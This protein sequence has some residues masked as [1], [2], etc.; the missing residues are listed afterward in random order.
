MRKIFLT[1]I[2][3]TFPFAHIVFAQ[4]L[5]TI[6]A[7]SLNKVKNSKYSVFVEEKL[8][9]WKK[10]GEFEKTVDWQK[11]VQDSTAI[12]KV[13]IQES[14]IDEY[15]KA[16][17]VLE[18]YY[19]SSYELNDWFYDS[20]GQYDADKEVLVVNTFWGN[21]PIPIPL[22]E[23]KNMQED[24]RD[25]H[26][27][28]ARFFIQNDQLAL[29]SLIFSNNS[30]TYTYENPSQLAQIARNQR[31]EL[32]QKKAKELAEKERIEKEKES[33]QVFTHAEQMPQFPGGETEMMS[34]LSQ[35]IKY[36]EE[37]QKQGIQGAV[38][39]RFIIGKN[40][41]VSDVTVLRS[42]DPSCDKEA[43]RVVKSMKWIPG[44]QNGNPVNVYY[45]MPVRF[46][47]Q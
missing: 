7:N 38:I 16:L 35:N 19:R 11:R 40:G 17:N 10:K 32:E 5:Q 44:K 23:A 3:F 1:I 12:K 4:N 47:L 28:E 18:Q 29:L 21:V 14:A 39:L 9:D 27:L 13:E 22:D 41:E 6:K 33:D 30:K 45:N 43:I 31:L 36:P 37:A 24:I 42:L 20:K 25:L 46:R 34:F 2:V 15:S 8:E 26:K